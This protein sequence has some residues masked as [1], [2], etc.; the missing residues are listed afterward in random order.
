VEGLEN[1]H[2]TVRAVALYSM[3]PCCSSAGFHYS[4]DSFSKLRLQLRMLTK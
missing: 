3:M 2:V 4:H 1:L